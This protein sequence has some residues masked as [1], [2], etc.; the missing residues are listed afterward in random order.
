MH[1]YF[2]ADNLPTTAHETDEL[3]KIEVLKKKLRE[4]HLTYDFTSIDQFKLRLTQDLLD[5]AGQLKRKEQASNADD[6]MHCKVDAQPI[7]A[8]AEGVT[9]RTSE[10]TLTFSGA[11]L[12]QGEGESYFYNIELWTS[13]S[14]NITNATYG[15]REGR[16]G[17]TDAALTFLSLEDFDVPHCHLAIRKAPHRISFECVEVRPS[18]ASKTI[19]IRISNVKVNCSQLGVPSGSSA[20]VALVV[21][22]K[23]LPG[24]TPALDIEKP[25]P[26]VAI[27]RNSLVFSVCSAKPDVARLKFSRSEGINDRFQV[28]EIL[29]GRVGPDLWLKFLERHSGVWRS[30]EQEGSFLRQVPIGPKSSATRFIARFSNVPSGIRLFVGVDAI[31]E[32][33]HCRGVLIESDLNGAGGG[34][35]FRGANRFFEVVLVS[36]VGQAVWEWADRMGSYRSE[37]ELIMIP[38]VLRAGSGEAS[39]GT[40]NVNG[41]LAPISCVAGG[42]STASVPR[43]VDTSANRIFFESTD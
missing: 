27:A 14:V 11:R 43:F 28:E 23:P 5:S 1:I 6:S 42:S 19:A 25:A 36:G 16:G 38:V 34:R 30:A 7:V 9:E 18:K 21:V 40:A 35:A 4:S 12:D 31:S 37:P 8:R 24:G 20:N 10:I 33:G 2:S 39:A 22:A 29:A 41:N 26:T 17:T 13:P 3:C 15:E 32:G